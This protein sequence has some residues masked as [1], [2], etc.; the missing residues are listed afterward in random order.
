MKKDL[1]VR[2]FKCGNEVKDITLKISP[3]T[4][5]V[6]PDEEKK[7][8]ILDAA[9]DELGYKSVSGNYYSVF[10][11]INEWLVNFGYLKKNEDRYSSRRQLDNIISTIVSK[12]SEGYSDITIRNYEI[13]QLSNEQERKLIKSLYDF[14]HKLYKP[15]FII[16]V[17]DPIMVAESLRLAES[18]ANEGTNVLDEDDLCC[19]QDV[20]SDAEFEENFS[21]ATYY[22]PKE[23]VP[24]PMKYCRNGVFKRKPKFGIEF[25][26]A[27]F[28]KLKNLIK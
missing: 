10:K 25:Y 18:F 4:L 11:D 13:D 12:V 26:E 3:I 2:N 5:L 16:S 19:Y 17:D 22:V 14:R 21:I 8:A 1:V 28:Y 23:G 7:D 6:G 15:N 20:M 24:Y 9:E 27:A